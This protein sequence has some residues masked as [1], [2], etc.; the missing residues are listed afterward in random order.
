V[1]IFIEDDLLTKN[2][3]LFLVGL[4]VSE[5]FA[6]SYWVNR[7]FVAINLSIYDIICHSSYLFL[8]FGKVKA[9]SSVITAFARAIG[10]SMFANALKAD[11]PLDNVLPLDGKLLL[12]HL[13]PFH[14]G[15]QIHLINLPQSGSP[16]NP[17]DMQQ[18][19]F[20]QSRGDRDVVDHVL[21]EDVVERRNQA[22][23][24]EV[25]APALV[26]PRVVPY[27]VI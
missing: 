23:A 19:L 4:L 2:L 12:D 24:V 10:L 18:S 5:T 15:P 7:I 3:H 17:S 16:H 13:Q 9:I 22:Q 20:Q 25:H 11:S 21:D 1:I 8:L 14:G 6:K 27:C 26:Q